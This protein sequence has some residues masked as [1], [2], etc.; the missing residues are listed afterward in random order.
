MPAAEPVIIVHGLWMH[1]WVM[2]WLGRRIRNC[3]FNVHRYSYPSMRLTLSENAERL[4]QYCERLAAPRVHVV[5]HSMGGLVALKMLA[6]T[7]SF[8]CGRLVL[9]GSPYGGSH[10]AER[11]VQLPGGRALLGHS[12][13][14]WLNQPRPT[15]SGADETGVIAGTRSF[16]LGRVV[17]PDLPRPNDGVVTM[18]ETEVPGVHHRVALPVSH[19]QMLVSRDV[20]RQSC[21]F[22]RRGQFDAAA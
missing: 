18:A 19:I 16:G 1:G 8:R 14:E 3:G 10:A 17:A 21:A 22:L 9:I 5:A 7:R 13:A 11:L 12:F 2:A 6:T 4:A 15:A 20:A